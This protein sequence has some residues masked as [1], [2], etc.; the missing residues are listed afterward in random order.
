MGLELLLGEVEEVVVLA[1]AV[2]VL[3]LSRDDVGEVL[4]QCEHIAEHL[5]HAVL[6]D[7]L[8]ASQALDEEA[9]DEGCEAVEQEASLDGR[10]VMDHSL[11]SRREGRVE[12]RNEAVWFLS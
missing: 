10:E 5:E 11:L 3:L 4:L 2:E 8:D 9:C 6:V 12:L 7:A 1:D